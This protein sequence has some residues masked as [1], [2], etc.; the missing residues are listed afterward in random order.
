MTEVQGMG[1]KLFGERVFITA[2]S[3]DPPRLSQKVRSGTHKRQE[4]TARRNVVCTIELPWILTPKG[5]KHP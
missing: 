3:I 4:T 2:R 5:S 1:D